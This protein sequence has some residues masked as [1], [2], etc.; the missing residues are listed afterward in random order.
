VTAEPPPITASAQALLR[1]RA[2]L[3][4]LVAH[5]VGDGPER[6]DIL[7]DVGLLTLTRAPQEVHSVRAWLATV[8][9]NVALRRRQRV[10]V[11]RSSAQRAARS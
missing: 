11:G 9:R 3:R 2:W 5:L 8:V 6:D 1:E 10:A 7:Q 4:G